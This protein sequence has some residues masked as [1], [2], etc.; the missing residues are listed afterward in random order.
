MLNIDARKNFCMY[1]TKRVYDRLDVLKNNLNISDIPE[2]AVRDIMVLY[3]K[4]SIDIVEDKTLTEKDRKI[5]FDH[6]LSK[7]CIKLDN[8]DSIRVSMYE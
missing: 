6:L 4:I 3:A 2:E 1:V 7:L 8:D 5:V